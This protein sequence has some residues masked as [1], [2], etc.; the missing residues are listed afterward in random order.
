MAIPVYLFLKDNAGNIIKGAVDIQG[1][2]NSIEVL[3]LH[4]QVSLPS[5]NASGKLTATRQH[6]AYLIEK[7]TD[8]ASPY[9]YQALTTGKNLKSA[10][11]KFYRIN[12]AGEEEEY[13]TTLLEGVRVVHVL[14]VM[15]D[16]KDPEKQNF[17]HMEAI[18]LSYEKITWHYLDGNIKHADSWQARQTA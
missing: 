18:E 2:E 8:S 6:L 11:L 7:E 12:D 17:N 9:L 4:H 5:D 14:S 3:G 1:R 13:F 10:E 15:F 16:I